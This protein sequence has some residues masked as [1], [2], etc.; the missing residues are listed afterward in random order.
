MRHLYQAAFQGSNGTWDDRVLSRLASLATFVVRNL[1][2][3]LQISCNLANEAFHF[4][5]EPGS[6]QTQ[7]NTEFL[8]MGILE[9][10]HPRAMTSLVSQFPCAFI[11]RA[12]I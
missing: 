9:G 8:T 12:E 5:V 2:E 11:I 1:D 6:V 4:F 3:N 7:V 10:L